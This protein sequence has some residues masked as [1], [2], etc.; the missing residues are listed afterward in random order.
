MAPLNQTIERTKYKTNMR[1][2]TEQRT[3][4]ASL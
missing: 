4:S 3:E 2:N 1:N